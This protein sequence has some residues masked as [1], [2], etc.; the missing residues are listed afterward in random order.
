MHLPDSFFRSWLRRD[1]DRIA[2]FLTLPF[3]RKLQPKRWQGA[4]SCNL[5]IWR[6]DF[7]RVGGF[8][9]SYEGWGFEDSDLAIRLIRAG[10]KRKDGRFATGVLHLWH[11]PNDRTFEAINL[12]RLQQRLAETDSK[13]DAAATGAAS[14]LPYR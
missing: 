7:E 8:D 2:P 4:K 3:P 6:S 12:R 11:A 9:E 13:E 1:I 14:L 10:V 5:G